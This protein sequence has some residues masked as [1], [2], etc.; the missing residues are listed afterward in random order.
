ML[1]NIS[2][3]NIPSRWAHTVQI[4]KMA[5]AWG[6]CISDFQLLIQAH[7]Q[8]QAFLDLNLFS[9][10]GVTEPFA[11]HALLDESLPLDPI[12]EGYHFPSFQERAAQYAIDQ[13]VRAVYTRA[14]QAAAICIKAGIP[15]LCETHVTTDHPD[16]KSL[17]SIAHEPAFRGLVTISELLESW[18]VEAGMP[19]EKILVWPDA[20]NLATFDKPENQK[21]ARAQL[22]I[23]SELPIAVYCGHLYANR[24]IEEILVAA[25]QLPEVSFLIVG[26][27]SK[28]VAVRKAESKHLNNISFTGFVDNAQVP[29]YLKAADILLMPFSRACASAPYM[30]PMKLFEYMAAERAIIATDLEAIKQH[31]THGNNALLCEPDNGAALA[32]AIQALC[33]DT[34]LAATLAT[35]ARRDVSRFT[36]RNRVASILDHFPLHEALTS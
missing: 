16:F 7:P 4:M 18:Y 35:N 24:G 25:K 17:L 3:G 1:L 34:T 5:E 27:W 21:T 23:E 26:G 33:D 9:H 10:Y 13:G 14:C 32:N 11:F 30:S 19:V 36:W 20:V 29:A 28:D 8:N 22:G 31:L 2:L 6:S 15:T 12:F